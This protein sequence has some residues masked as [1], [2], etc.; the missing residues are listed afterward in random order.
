MS[1]RRIAASERAPNAGTRCSRSALS[2]MR[3]P[4]SLAMSEPCHLSAYFS[5][6]TRPARGSTY[7]PVTMLAVTSSS[8]RWASSFRSKWRACSLPSRSR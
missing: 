5:K 4:A 6:V 1:L 2:V 8:H 7:C 3:S